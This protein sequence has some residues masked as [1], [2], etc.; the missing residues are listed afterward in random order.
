MHSK[1]KP[2]KYHENVLVFSPGT[3]VH[4][5]QSSKRM[6]YNPQ[7]ESG[8]PYKKTARTAN[9][10][11]LN[12]PP[13]KANL[14]FIGHTSINNGTRYPASVLNFSIHNVGLI[15]P[16]QKPVELFEYLIKTYS[17]QGGIILDNCIGSGT[18]A[19]AAMR[20]GRNWI[21]IEKEEKYVI[22]ANKRIEEERW[23]QSIHQRI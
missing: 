23:K 9:A 12:H 11:S 18:T 5:N 13:S 6:T 1:N 20:T 16:T 17:D 4:K 10:G 8:K 7:M 14:D 3:T 19:I 22:P 21:G 2:L 15:H